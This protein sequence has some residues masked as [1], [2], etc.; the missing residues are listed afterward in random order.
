MNI[1]KTGNIKTE[2]NYVEGKNPVHG[3]GFN[4]WKARIVWELMLKEN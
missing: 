1:L 3:N 2:G 4:G